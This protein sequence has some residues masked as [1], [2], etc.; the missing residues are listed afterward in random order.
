M[1]LNHTFNLYQSVGQ[2]RVHTALT[3]YLDGA[4]IVITKGVITMTDRMDNAMPTD[5]DPR[6]FP[7]YVQKVGGMLFAHAE[8]EIDQ[9]KY[10]AA[11]SINDTDRVN[12]IVRENIKRN[13]GIQCLSIKH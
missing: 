12:D 11:A 9:K 7:H 8:N 13:R 4:D 5:I 2:L 10:E 3:Y 1:A 6:F